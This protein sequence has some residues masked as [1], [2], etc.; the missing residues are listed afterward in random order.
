MQFKV[1]IL[2][3][4]AAIPT[5]E[6]NPSAHYIEVRNHF[7]LFDCAEGTQLQLRKYV[8]HPQRVN[9][10]FISHLHGDHFFG[11]VGM[12]T[13][14]H[15]LGRQ[16]ELHLYGPEPLKEILD[17]QL[18]HSY[19]ELI[20]P[21]VFHPVDTTKARVIMENDQISVSAIPLDHRIPT[22]GF[23]VKEKPLGRKIRKEFAAENNVPLEAFEHI[24]KGRDFIDSSGRVHRNA[25]ITLDPLPPR[26]YAYITDTA[27][28]RSIIPYVK[29]V[30]LIYHEATF[31]EDKAAD[32]RA[33]YHTTAREAATIAREAGAGKLLIGHFSAR[34]TDTAIL[35]EEA[36]KVFPECDLAYDGMVVEL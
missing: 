28:T 20:Y 5:L 24:K 19:T 16:N 26:S 36:R 25:D 18:R 30:S 4:G 29:E 13:S 35:L 15:L 7:L 12:V 31:A 32:A 27:L 34:Y 3:S 22:C 9:H 8:A 23:L 2:G 6:R 11:L 10:V 14:F 17:L 21:L 1:T 33:K